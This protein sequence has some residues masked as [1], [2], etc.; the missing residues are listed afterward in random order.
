MRI[1]LGALVVALLGGCSTVA[2]IRQNSSLVSLAS[3]NSSESVAECIRDGWQTTSV[4]G[5]SVGGVLQKSVDG[6]AVIAPNAE[7]PWHVVDIK[8]KGTGSLISYRFYRT[9]QSPPAAVPET[10]RR[11]AM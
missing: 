9:W 10:V 3:K 6:Y 7:N 2:D 1:L 4:I 5:G 11:C 8:T